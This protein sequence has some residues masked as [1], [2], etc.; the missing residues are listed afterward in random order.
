MTTIRDIIRR[1]YLSAEG[2]T[3]YPTGDAADLALIRLQDIINGLVLS[4]TGSGDWTDVYTT[5]LSTYA[6]TDGKRVYAASTCTVTLA[7]TT[8]DDDGDTVAVEDLSR[9]HI[10]GT[11][12]NAGL[13]VYAASKGAWSQVDGLEVAD[14]S[15]F[16][17]E[18]D[19]GLGVDDAYLV[20]SEMGHRYVSDDSEV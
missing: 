1:A 11:A 3:G 14:E 7:T 4:R 2:E 15:P 12:T 17:L 8:T 13:W 18:D 10:I 19:A 9:V 6:A 20:L 5:G 16:G